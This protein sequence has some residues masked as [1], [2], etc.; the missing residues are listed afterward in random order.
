M[1]RKIHF[2]RILGTLLTA[3]LVLASCHDDDSSVMDTS[4]MLNQT[5]VPTTY[6][7]VWNGSL[8]EQRTDVCAVFHAIDGKTDQMQ[9]NISG[10]IPSVDEDQMLQV[11]VS[12]KT[13]E[14]Q[15][16]GQFTD[17]RYELAVNGSWF[18]Y[19][20]GNYFKMKCTY[21]ILGGLVFDESS[22]LIPEHTVEKNNQRILLT[23]K[24]DASLNIEVEKTE[25]G[26]VT[27]SSLTTA[28]YW[29][30]KQEGK[31]IIDLTETQASS[32][33]EKWLE[34]TGDD[35]YGNMQRYKDFNRYALYVNVTK[36][37][38]NNNLVR[39]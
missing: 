24:N 4:T 39:L 36:S 17:S 21:K 27:M 18:P 38:T 37:E 19:E 5:L 29:F 7:F 14:V 9:M 8:K 11:N 15:Y 1:K 13:D 22:E 28:S 32:L 10:I 25:E 6:S 3:L 16:A 12:P 34:I 30:S 26:K 23:F 2:P 33:A 20:N 35:L 31:V